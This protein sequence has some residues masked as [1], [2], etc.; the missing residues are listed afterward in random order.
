VWTNRH[1]PVASPSLQRM[2]SLTRRPSRV[3]GGHDVS[4]G[5]WL[6]VRFHPR[7]LNV[8]LGPINCSRSSPLRGKHRYLSPL[9]SK[10]PNLC[11]LVRPLRPVE[12]SLIGLRAELHVIGIETAPTKVINHTTTD[13]GAI[14]K[15]YRHTMGIAGGDDLIFKSGMLRNVSGRIDR[16]S[17]PRRG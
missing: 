2:S 11:P 5:L 9:R 6:R 1:S 16:A 10:T 8:Y 4:S 3:T 14:D 17:I 15:D 13:A 7:T 12:T